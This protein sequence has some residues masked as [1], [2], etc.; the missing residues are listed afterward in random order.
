MQRRRSR[1]GE[2]KEGDIVH[3]E[4]EGTA[5]A[6]SDDGNFFYFISLIDYFPFRPFTHRFTLL[7][8]FASR[9]YINKDKKSQT[10]YSVGGGDRLGPLT[11]T[12]VKRERKRLYSY[13]DHLS[14]A[15]FRNL[16]M[17]KGLWCFE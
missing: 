17:D 10:S 13:L 16:I 1:R 9:T 4:K 7:L 14:D 5:V 6:I 8:S 12:S 15:Q 2:E 3:Q 11:A